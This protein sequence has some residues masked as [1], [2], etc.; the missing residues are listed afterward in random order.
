MY[1]AI[2]CCSYNGI[3]FDLKDCIMIWSIKES[4]I[5]Y[6]K[7]PYI[8]TDFIYIHIF[9]G[10]DESRQKRL[11]DKTWQKVHE[12]RAHRIVYSN[13]HAKDFCKLQLQKAINWQHA[14][15]HTYIH[16][17]KHKQFFILNNHDTYS[18]EFLCTSL[19]RQYRKWFLNSFLFTLLRRI[20]VG[21][22]L[23]KEMRIGNVHKAS[24]HI[25]RKLI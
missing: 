15:V 4:I 21:K 2:T 17:Y 6:I 9:W 5:F 16:T 24:S 1:L 20:L 7:L 12:I 19:H 8:N 22:H 23:N 13:K 18:K 3:F 10:S 25:E 11:S 14:Y